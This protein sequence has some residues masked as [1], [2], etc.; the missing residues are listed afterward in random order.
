MWAPA[1]TV[2]DSFAVK[3]LK[4]LKERVSRNEK[5]SLLTFR[6]SWYWF[7]NM[8]IKHSTLESDRMEWLNDWWGNEMDVSDWVHVCLQYSA[9]FV[10]GFLWKKKVSPPWL[11]FLIAVNRV[12]NC[13]HWYLDSMGQI[14]LR[15]A[16]DQPTWYICRHNIHAAGHGRTRH[17]NRISWL[18]WS[19]ERKQILSNDGN[20]F[21]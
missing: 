18:L 9:P 19:L 16:A 13:S 11:L 1:N 12:W 2:G 7:K 8:L 3:F 15:S 5:R 6:A 21:M 20:D 4:V 14:P 10:M 17:L